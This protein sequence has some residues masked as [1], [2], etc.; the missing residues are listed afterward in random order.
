MRIRNAARIILLDE[1][2][3]ILLFKLEDNTVYSPNE[4]ALNAFWVTPGGGLKENESFEEAA[5]RELWEETGIKQVEIGSWVWTRDKEV[6][7]KG[8]MILSHERFFVVRINNTEVLLD[9]L[10]EN[11]QEV[12][13]SHKWWS[14]QE[15][16][17]SNDK[18]I[19]EKLGSL[20]KPIVEGILPE[21][22]IMII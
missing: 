4:P 18:I 22:P 14:I 19:P 10:T 13:R 5:I 17:N 20:L 8:E 9:N 7:W 11:E 15:L 16:E 21:N 2:N 3:K 1:N 12:Y 6:N